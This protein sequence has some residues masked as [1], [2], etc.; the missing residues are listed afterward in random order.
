LNSGHINVDDMNF[1]G[2]E[3]EDMHWRGVVIVDQNVFMNK[4][5]KNNYLAKL[6]S[7]SSSTIFGIHFT[8]VFLKG[9]PGTRGTI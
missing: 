7:F 9:R 4:I 1:D 3:D 8:R 6:R 5:F 2:I